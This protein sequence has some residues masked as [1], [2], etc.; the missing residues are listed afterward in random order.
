MALP[1][2]LDVLPSWGVAPAVAEAAPVAGS[3]RPARVVLPARPRVPLPVDVLLARMRRTAARELARHVPMDAQ[4]CG[5]CGEI[6]PCA[7]ARQA[8]L[9]LS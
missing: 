7:R 8:D 3:M 5:C 6:W 9:A 1:W 4:R 2:R